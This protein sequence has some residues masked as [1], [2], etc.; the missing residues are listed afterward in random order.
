[1]KFKN[2]SYKIILYSIF[3]ILF[4]FFIIFQINKPNFQTNQGNYIEKINFDLNPKQFSSEKELTEFIDS[5]GYESSNLYRTQEFADSLESVNIESKSSFQSTTDYSQT[6]VQVAGIDEG[7]II[8]TDGN[9]IYT[10]SNKILYIIKAYPGTEAEIVS[11]IHLNYTPSSLFINQNRLIV[12]GNYDF[13]RNIDYD[14]PINIDHVSNVV[15]FEVY[16]ITNKIE[17][18]KIKEYKFDGNYF[19]SRMK[20]DYVYIV[21]KKYPYSTQPIPYIIENNEITKISIN[22]IYYYDINYRQPTYVSVHAID[23]KT[24]DD[25][26]SKLFLV[27]GSQNLYMSHD[28]MYISYN[29]YI[30]EYKIQE[31]IA[32]QLIEKYLNEDDKILIEKIKLTDN[33]ILSQ[34]EKDE[35]ILEIYGKAALRLDEKKIEE[36]QDSSEE[37]MKEKLE[38]FKYFEYTVIHKINLDGKNIKPVSNNKVPGYVNNQF[39]FDEKENILRV[40]TTISSHYSYVT[41]ERTEMSN[42]VYTLDKNL[43]E[44][45]S[46]KG[47]AKGE[48]IYS[49]RFIGDR[50]YMVTFRQIDPFFVIDLS[51]PNDIKQLGELKIPGFSTYLHPYD[52]NTIIGIGKDASFTGRTKGLKISLFDVTDVYNPKEITNYISEERYSSSTAL[53][54]HKAFLFSREK[55]LLV[56]PAY[57]YDY[58]DTSKNYNGAFVFD[59]SKDKIKLRGIIDH[60]KFSDRFSQVERSLYIEELL[61][62]KS[63]K[64][65]RINKIETLESVKNIELNFTSIGVP[66][67]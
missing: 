33:S 45:D 15:N 60:S 18:K 9:Y 14:F 35:K 5:H 57:N 49:T 24:P 41:K 46:I 52:D 21:V 43:V 1:M 39:S 34:S 4:L 40:A 51:N 53:Y 12:F 58:S 44:L 17:P 61:Y 67:F 54:E 20:G 31:E 11:T 23:I 13:S 66:V 55:N 3:V 32:K 7:D 26:S 36:L 38:E 29:Q 65:L 27:E 56:I 25:V 8:K 2:N 22:D 47:I 62:T 48:R 37:L 50:L 59:I 42:N 63:L 6:N 10:I 30:D 64:V 28:N 19:E 16:D